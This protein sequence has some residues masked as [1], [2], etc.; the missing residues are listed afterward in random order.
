MYV[1]KLCSLKYVYPQNKQT[2]FSDC[3]ILCFLVNVP[4]AEDF[5]SQRL[6]ESFDN[7]VLS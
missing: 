3:L 1:R 7:F 2:V 5:Y 4:R 6:I